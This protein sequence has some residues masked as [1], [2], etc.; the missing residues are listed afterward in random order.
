MSIQ[1]YEPC[2][3]WGFAE[4]EPCESMCERD[5]GDYVLYT[6]HAAEVERLT[7]ERDDAVARAEK[8]EAD[9]FHFCAGLC[10]HPDGVIGDEGGSNCCPITGTRD[11]NTVQAAPSARERWLELACKEVLATPS[12]GAMRSADAVDTIKIVRAALAAAPDKP[13]YAALSPEP[14]GGPE[15]EEE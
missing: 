15:G 7:A 14:W 3:E 8:A 12:F 6:A 5:D 13:Q 2:L 11:A 9:A 4:D 1:R 10:V